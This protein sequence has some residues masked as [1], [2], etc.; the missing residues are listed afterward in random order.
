MTGSQLRLSFKLGERGKC[1]YA[2]VVLRALHFVFSH[3]SW[4]CVAAA[5]TTEHYAGDLSLRCNLHRR[6]KMHLQ[7]LQQR[8]A[9]PLVGV[10][11]F[12]LLRTSRCDANFFS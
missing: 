6:L 12:S 5:S 3:M 9:A 1:P 4:Q 10:A 2:T 11:F 7:W 8:T